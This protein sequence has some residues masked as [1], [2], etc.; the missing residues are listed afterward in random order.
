MRENLEAAESLKTLVPRYVDALTR[1]AITA[2]LEEQVRAGL[3]DAGGQR[4]EQRAAD[5]PGWRRLLL[6]CAGERP[7]ATVAEAVR[8]RL[9]E[10]D[11]VEDVAALLAWRATGSQPKSMRYG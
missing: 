1:A 10:I 11:G 3:R 8:S 2:K 4:L 9:I 7:R 5:A 6:T